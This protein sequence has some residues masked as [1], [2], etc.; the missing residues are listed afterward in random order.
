[1]FTLLATKVV[2][3]IF[4]FR[5]VEM[6]EKRKQDITNA[7]Y[8][9]VGNQRKVIEAQSRPELKGHVLDILIN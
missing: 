6:E 1:M 9:L 3:W 4:F 8:T 5:K 7:L 2:F